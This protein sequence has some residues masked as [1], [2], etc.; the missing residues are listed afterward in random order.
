VQGLCTSGTLDG[1]GLQKDIRAL[2]S[3]PNGRQNG[4]SEPTLEEGIQMCIDPHTRNMVTFKCY[5]TLVCTS[6]RIYVPLEPLMV[7]ARKSVPANLTHAK[8]GASAPN[9]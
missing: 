1:R 3:H 7:G 8:K 6:Q 2:G 4:A 9:L 5:K